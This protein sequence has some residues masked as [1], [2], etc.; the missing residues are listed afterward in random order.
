[1]AGE[2]LDSGN[3][4]QF[5]TGA[6]RDIDENKGAMYLVP[7]DIASELS[8]YFRQRSEKDTKEDEW[9][10]NEENMFNDVYQF[11]LSK[12]ISNIL[13]LLCRFVYTH[14][15]DNIDTAILE[16]SKQY[17]GGKNKYGAYNWNK[18]IS[19]HS[20]IDSGM[21]H[22]LKVLRGDNDE[23]HDRAFMWNFIGLLWTLKHKPELDDIY[24]GDNYSA[25]IIDAYNEKWSS[26]N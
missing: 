18:G 6:V 21:R 8:T 16:V 24:Y 19:T 9:I 1:M 2:I 17:S 25:D 13:R 26:K 14:Y 7:L 11:T 22:G 3:R 15:N 12:D 5:S 10:F 4:R 20:F 23:P